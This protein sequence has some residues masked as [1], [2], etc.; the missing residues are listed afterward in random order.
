M[1]QNRAIEKPESANSPDNVLDFTSTS[2]ELSSNLMRQSETR[3]DGSG[4]VRIN[5]HLEWHT[6]DIL[7]EAAPN[8]AYVVRDIKTLGK[9]IAVTVA[10]TIDGVTRE[11]LG[12]GLARSEIGIEKAEHD[13]LKWAA[14][15]FRI[16]RKLYRRKF[17]A[18]EREISVRMN[19]P[20]EFPAE[21]VARNFADLVT[22]K[23]LAMIRA[24]ARDGA[25]DPD[26]EC[27]SAM[28][29]KIGEL[30]RSAASALI[31]RLQEILLSQRQ[32]L[33]RRAS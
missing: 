26:Q 13:A 20:T 7:D 9:I 23:Q 12:T 10:I 17:G 11:G 6:V 8:W 15:K 21:P 25:I 18:I 28:R 33:M 31:V 24:I 4:N 22:P 29:C 5:E 14:M 1:K 2:R 30:T 27:K 19:G 3:R 16:A 32:V